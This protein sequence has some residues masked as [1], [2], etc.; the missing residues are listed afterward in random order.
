MLLQISEPETVETPQFALGID[1]GTTYCV[2]SLASPDDVKLLRDPKHGAL[3]PSIVVKNGQDVLCGNDALEAFT[4]NPETGVKSIKRVLETDIDLEISTY[5]FKHIKSEAFKRCGFEV[6]YAV[7]TVPAYFDDKRRNYIRQAAMNAGFEVMRLLAEPTA[8]AL[9]YG[10]EKQED[11]LFGV[12][13]LGG[14]TFDFSLLRLHQGVFQV[15]ATGGDADLGGDDFDALLSEKL[16]RDITPESLMNAKKIKETLSFGDTPEIS[17]AQFESLIWPLLEKTTKIVHQTLEEKQVSLSDLKG[18]IFVGGSTRIPII[19][20]LFQTTILDDI[21]P[22]EVVGLGAG[23]HA[24]SLISDQDRLLLDVTPLS[25][26]IETMGGIVD[27]IIPRN[28]AIPVSKAQNFTTHQNSQQL[29]KIHILQGERDFA[30][31]CKSLGEFVLGPIPD[32]P[33]GIPRIQVI[34]HIDAD[35]LLVVEAKDLDS[36]QKETMTVVPVNNLSME[37]VL[38]VIQEASQNAKDDISQRLLFQASVKGSSLIEIVESVM[39]LFDEKEKDIVHEGVER[40][41]QALKLQNLGE[42]QKE[43]KMIS[44]MT[45]PLANMQLKDVLKSLR[46]TK[47]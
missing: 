2:L 19:K 45:E 29:I 5:I 3:I 4:L 28:T 37:E 12:Y 15:L 7:V 33:A 32:A 27:W 17:K 42:I 13:D 38:S 16:F 23:H 47:E 35:G 44:K 9:A 41:R 39:T 36:D 40:L 25:L 18:I 6:T 46:E 10:L 30:A 8:A 24:Q 21:H 43:V 11:G 34:F 31:Q 14:G 1:F 20:T 22:D 26:G